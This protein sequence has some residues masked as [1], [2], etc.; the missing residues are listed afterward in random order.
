MRNSLRRNEPELGDSDGES[1]RIDIACGARALAS[2]KTCGSGLANCDG[3][4]W[5]GVG[6]NAVGGS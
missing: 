3:M 4:E 5:E 6:A 1:R 2:L